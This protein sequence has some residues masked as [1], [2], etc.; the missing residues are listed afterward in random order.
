MVHPGSALGSCLAND[1]S[2]ELTQED[3]PRAID[4]RGAPRHRSLGTA[5]PAAPPT[6][7]CSGH[8]TRRQSFPSASKGSGASRPTRQPLE[9]TSSTT[10]KTSEGLPRGGWSK[11]TQPDTQSVIIEQPDDAQGFFGSKTPARSRTH[12]CKTLLDS[13]T[14]RPQTSSPKPPCTQSVSLYKG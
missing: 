9:P 5:L 11:L 8:D 7:S 3:K 10:K 12:H 1:A 6:G 13:G 4:A 2:Q 14:R